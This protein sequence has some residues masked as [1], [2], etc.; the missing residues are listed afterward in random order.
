MT[1]FTIGHRQ[2][3]RII[4]NFTKQTS[5]INKTKLTLGMKPICHSSLDDL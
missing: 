4:C 3:L 5:S 1:F 2:G